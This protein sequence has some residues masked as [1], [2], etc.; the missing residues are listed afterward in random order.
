VNAPL[1][2]NSNTLAALLGISI[3]SAQRL[4]TDGVLPS[5]VIAG[6]SVVPYLDVCL[7]VDALM[8]AQQQ[9]HAA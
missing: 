4:I 5:V 1:T 6:R 7:Y 2:V 8:T 9:R 3:R